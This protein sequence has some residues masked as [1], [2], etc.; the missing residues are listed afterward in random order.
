M[1]KTHTNLGLPKPCVDF[2]KYLPT[3]KIYFFVILGVIVN[4]S[5]VLAASSSS[6]KFNP[7]SGDKSEMV[8][9]SQQQIKVTGKITDATNGETLPGVNIVVK[10]TTSG[11]LTDMDGV[12]S[13]NVPNKNTTLV[14]SFVGYVAQEIVVGVEDGA[15]GFKFDKRH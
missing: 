1:K 12:Y 7:G 2:R 5:V 8:T 9:T 15:V 3:L 10:G 14:F 13:I 11:T 6:E 4:A